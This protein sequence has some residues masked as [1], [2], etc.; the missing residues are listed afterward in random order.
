MQNPASPP[1]FRRTCPACNRPVGPGYKFCETCG[2]RIPELSTCSKCGTQFI[3]PVKFCDLCG[4]RVIPGEVRET[5]EVPE[6]A[7]G[8]ETG[9][10]GD[11]TS[12]PDE[13][14]IPEPDTDELPVDND[15]EIIEPAEEETRH[16]YNKEIPEPDTDE[17]PVDNDEEIIEPAE[18]KPRQGYKEEIP[19]PDTDELLDKYGEDYGEDETLESSRTPRPLSPIKHA[20]KKPVPVPAPPGRGSSEAVDDALF[21]S[22]G[23]PGAPAKRRVNRTRIIGGCIV[24]VAIIA[25]VYFIGLPMLTGT[26]GT[27]AHSNQTGV[28]TGPT[29]TGTITPALTATP[30]PASR[31]LVPL[32]TQ[33]LPSGQKIYFYVQKNPVTAKISVIFTGSAGAGSIVSA[34]IKVTHPD[35]SVTTGIIL[36]LKGVAEQTLDGSNKTDRVEIIAKMS[37]GGTYRVYDEL[38]PFTG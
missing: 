37:S 7:G 38:V 20:A 16:R 27:G 18:E 8:E 2:T 32:P 34:D 12:E 30:V 11:Q 29:V 35:G 25:A 5:D 26:W 36:P 28:E 24:L 31:A 23:K 9:P 1:K 33:L 19:E 17:L 6:N 21:L 13:E 4:A 22:P 3:A 15:E 10:V 14:G